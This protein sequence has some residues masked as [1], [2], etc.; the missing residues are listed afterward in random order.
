[1]MKKTSALHLFIEGLKLLL[2]RNKKSLPYKFC[3]SARLGPSLRYQRISIY[4]FSLQIILFSSSNSP[5][6]DLYCPKRIDN[7]LEPSCYMGHPRSHLI[8]YSFGVLKFCTSLGGG[9]AKISDKNLYLKM[10]EIYHKDPVQQIEQYYSNVK[11][12]FYF[13]W[14]LNV[15]YVIKPLMSIVRLL[16]LN[17]MEFVVKRLRAFTKTPNTEELFLS[18]RRQPCQPLLA[19]LYHRLQTYDYNHLR[20]QKENALYVL[21]NLQTNSIIKFIGMNVKIKNFWLFPIVVCQPDL[22]VKIL[23]KYHIDAYRGTTQLNVITKQLTDTEENLPISIDD[24]HKCPNAEYLIEHVIYLPVH[25]YV[26]KHVL[27]QLIA[28]V[29]RTAK[30]IEKY[31]LRSKL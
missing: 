26:P 11:K 23:S 8:L 6:F 7:N 30:E 15:P 2:C 4:R 27:N 17:H 20:I 19:F 14:I 28:I 25:C 3:T 10:S 22:F 21:N 13:Y 12:Y 16:N 29:N 5:V 1:M 9:L 31:Q 18:L 24:H